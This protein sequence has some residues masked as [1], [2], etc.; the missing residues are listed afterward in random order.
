MIWEKLPCK[1]T[2]VK[3]PIKPDNCLGC[4]PKFLKSKKGS[5]ISTTKTSHM[6]PVMIKE[7]LKALDHVDFLK[8]AYFSSN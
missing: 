7:I 5:N 6:I 8:L 3:I 2:D 1:N 4:I